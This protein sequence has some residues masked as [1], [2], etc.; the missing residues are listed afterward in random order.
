MAAVARC[1]YAVSQLTVGT[2][3]ATWRHLLPDFGRIIQDKR[4]EEEKKRRTWNNQVSFALFFL[5]T[6]LDISAQTLL[7]NQQDLNCQVRSNPL[8]CNS[9]LFNHLLS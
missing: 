9:Y 6:L 7:P 8:Y 3:L 1:Y 2:F 5:Y 4:Q